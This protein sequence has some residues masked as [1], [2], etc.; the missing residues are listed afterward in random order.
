[1]KLAAAPA[2]YDRAEQAQMRGVLER[3]DQQNLK[4][5]IALPNMLLSSPDGKVWRLTINDSGVLGVAA[6]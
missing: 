5:G 3:A 1:M 2:A 6:V 4:R